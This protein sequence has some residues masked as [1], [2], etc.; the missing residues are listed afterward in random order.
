MT[1]RAD[2]EFYSGKDY[3]YETTINPVMATATRS[4]VGLMMNMMKDMGPG[5]VKWPMDV[6]KELSPIIKN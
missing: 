1:A 3:F 5:N 6:K 4:L 2:F